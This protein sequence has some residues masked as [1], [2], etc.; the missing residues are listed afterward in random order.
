MSASHPSRMVSFER[1][2]RIF[3]QWGWRKGPRVLGALAL[4][5]AAHHFS[6]DL[7]EDTLYAKLE[8]EG[9]RIEAHEDLV[10]VSGNGAELL[11]RRFSTDLHVFNQI[12]VDDEFKALF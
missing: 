7:R 2:Q 4:Q 6:K 8:R 3:R 1:A 11:C 9:Y 5:K 12:F 10:L